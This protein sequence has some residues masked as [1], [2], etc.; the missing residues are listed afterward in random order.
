MRLKFFLG[1]VLT[2]SGCLPA[3]S[4]D[5]SMFRGNP[6]HSGVYDAAGV[7][8]FGQVKWKF[9]TGGKVISSP[10]VSGGVVFVGSTDGNFY[11]VDRES[12]TLKWK[13]AAKSRI[14]SSPAVA[15]GQVYFGAYD[16]NFYAVNA[17]TGQLSW[18]FQTGGERRFAATH[19]H[20]SQPAAE[21][22]PDP[23]DFYLSS[24]VVWSGAVLFGS[25]DGNIYSV[26][27]ASGA[28]KWKFKTGDVVHASPA[29][30][31]GTLFIGSWDS[32]FYAL[33]AATGKEKWRFKTGEDPDTHNQV[34]IQSSAAVVDGM[35]YFGCRDS[36]FYALDAATGQKKWAFSNHG[37][38]VIGSPAVQNRKVY[39]ATSDTSLFYALDTKT[40]SLIFSLKFQGW[41]LFS[42]PAIAGSMLYI[43]SHMGKLI[44]ID[45]A[46]QTA[47]WMFETDGAEQ[48]AAV[49]SKADGAPNYEAAFQS[50][51]Y[52]DIVSG[53]TK[54]MAIGTILSSPVVV[55]RTIYV[56]SA[57]GNLYALI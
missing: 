47:S 4:A 6:E 32:Y 20:G 43:G 1:I 52:D 56:G 11:A 24:P 55:E 40:G 22:M 42:S 33:D 31:R 9:H 57:D 41:P 27:A 34:G 38:W 15:G 16:G 37:S 45:L 21:T 17:A 50:D 14:T 51:F 7:E 54:M 12:G 25:G 53:V 19:L 35:V 46:S 28:L 30:A 5:A 8:K 23:F 13:F 39:F 10:A 48:N 3:F 29:I 26:D 18:K 49:W 2:V 44:A 36:N